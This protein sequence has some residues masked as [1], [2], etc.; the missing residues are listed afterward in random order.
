[1]IRPPFNERGRSAEKVAGK[2]SNET[3]QEIK[4]GTIRFNGKE[5]PAV[6][7]S[8][9]TRARE[10]ATTLKQWIQSGELLLTDPGVPL[11]T[12]SGSER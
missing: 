6:P 2:K 5:V 1:M 7:L 12:A 8:S 11:P 3:P 10:V 4:S 9:C